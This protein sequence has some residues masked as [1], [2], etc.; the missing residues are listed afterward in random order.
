MAVIVQ[1]SIA[2]GSF[3]GVETALIVVVE[4]GKGA[5]IEIHVQANRNCRHPSKFVIKGHN[6]GSDRGADIVYNRPLR[7][8]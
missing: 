4:L 1:L 7:M 2:A 6:A 8:V 3:G 5:D